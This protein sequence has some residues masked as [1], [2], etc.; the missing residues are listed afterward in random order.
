MYRYLMKWGSALLL[1]LG[2]GCS[3]PTTAGIP[4]VEP[5]DIRQY[6]GLWYEIARLPNWFETGM[7][8][9]TAL[10]TLEKDGTVKV[11][12]SGVKNG[13]KTQITGKARFAVRP[14]VGNLRVRFFYPFS[15]VYKV[16]YLDSCYTVAIVT[17]SDYSKLWILA[18]TPQIS[19][20]QLE[21]LV[22]KV[23]NLGFESG[24][25]IYSANK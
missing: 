25:L 7:T 4:A 9:I 18:R 23:T 17:G 1:A 15:S 8:N 5:F 19:E 16:I 20:A 21:N 24:N 12:N 10:Y 22:R 2:W 11:V 6:T 13:R 3:D 14:G